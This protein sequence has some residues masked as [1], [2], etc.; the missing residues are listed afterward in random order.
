MIEVLPLDKCNNQS[1]LI[2]IGIPKFN[3]KHYLDNSIIGVYYVDLENNT[4][5]YSNNTHTDWMLEENSVPELDIL[6]SFE[7]K[8]LTHSCIKCGIDINF[9]Y[10]SNLKFFDFIPIKFKQYM[11]KYDNNELIPLVKLFE[12]CETIIKTFIPKLDLSSAK[13]DSA[14][15]IDSLFYE[16]LYKTEGNY[17]TKNSNAI[18]HFYSDYNPYTITN[19]PTNSSGGINFTALSKK[20]DTRKHIVPESANIFVQFDYSAFHPYLISRILNIDIPQNVDYYIYLNEKFSFSDSMDRDKIK[21]DFFKLIYGYGKSKN[22]FSDKIEEFENVLYSQYIQTGAIRSFF[23]KRHLFF[24]P[25]LN[26]NVIFNY[27]LQNMET[28]H[29]L[30]KIKQLFELIPDCKTMLTLYIYDSFVFQI[31]ISQTEIINK[32]KDVLTSE[33]FPVKVYI[34]NNLQDLEIV[35]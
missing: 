34:G 24:K 4:R 31:P 9:M 10:S 15:K 32:I 29:N 1:K 20:D 6:L 26:K 33:G 8:L 22:N 27:F 17:I 13:L 25:N 21:E 12:I 35:N 3:R 5:Y 16:T 30:L 14:N 11:S 2:Q 7:K 19:R 28:E 23:L 18:E